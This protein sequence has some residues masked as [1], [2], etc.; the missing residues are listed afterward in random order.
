M[1]DK[2]YIH[3][4]LYVPF[5]CLTDDVKLEMEAVL[6][7][8]KVRSKSIQCGKIEIGYVFIIG[9]GEDRQRA[10]LF[11]SAMSKAVNRRNVF[12]LVNVKKPQMRRGK[13]SRGVRWEYDLR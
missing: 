2:K 4:E 6:K 3:Y 1:T 5:S 10:E 13:Q 12:Q 9:L 8:F 7:D 11:K